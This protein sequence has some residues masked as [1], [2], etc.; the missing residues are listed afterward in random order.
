MTLL[1][2]ASDAVPALSGYEEL[3]K[4]SS[5]ICFRLIIDL[6]SVFILVRFI[7]YPIYKHR[8]LFFT[9]FIFNIIIFLI[10]FLLNKVDLSMGAAF[11]LF[12]VFSMLRYKTEEIAIKDMTYLFLVIAIGLVSAVTKVKDTADNIEYLFLIGINGVVL[13]IT[14]LL[15]SNIFMKKESVKTILYENIELIKADRKEELLA[16]IRLRTGFNVHRYSIHKI[17]F[18]KDAAQIKIYFYEN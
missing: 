11:G 7:Y 9:Y 3:Q 6:A 5:K 4:L 13:L 12:A 15:E 8:E 18:L 16:D 10:S 14:Y 1:Q 17:D 2:L